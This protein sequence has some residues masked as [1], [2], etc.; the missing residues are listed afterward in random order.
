MQVTREVYR[1]QLII[2]WAEKIPGTNFWKGKA[3]ISEGYGNLKPNRLE[4]PDG[5]LE[6]EK[7]ARDYIFQAAKEWIDNRFK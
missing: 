2:W 6:T 1:A 7:E 5:G 3:A 4:G